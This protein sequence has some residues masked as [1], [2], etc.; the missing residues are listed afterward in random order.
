MSI[1]N[2]LAKKEKNNILEILPKLVSKQLVRVH[3]TARQM[4]IESW[5]MR[6]TEW[7]A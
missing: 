2:L 1:L 4:G 3:S 5:K 6:E 7:E